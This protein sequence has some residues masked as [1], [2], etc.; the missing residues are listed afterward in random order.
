MASA[1]SITPG[2]TSNNAFSIWRAKNGITP[3]TNG[4]NAAVVPIVVPAKIR[5][6]G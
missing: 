1:A 3:I 2:S 5:V 4:T 6:N